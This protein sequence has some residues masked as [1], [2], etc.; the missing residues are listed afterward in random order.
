MFCIVIKIH[1]FSGFFT[2][3]RQGSKMYEMVHEFTSS[4]MS[5][6]QKRKGI[7]LDFLKI[8][9]WLICFRLYEGDNAFLRDKKEQ[10][11]R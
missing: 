10:L 9:M 6:L 8:I 5:V 1:T 3:Y 7:R 11:V 2:C 4:V